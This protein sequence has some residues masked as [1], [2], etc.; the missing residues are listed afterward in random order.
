MNGQLTLNAVDGLRVDSAMHV[1]TGFWSGFASAA[2]VFM[3][4]EVLEGSPSYV[5]P[6]QG[7]MGS[8]LNY[9]V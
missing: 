7:Y 8:V 3:T 6:Y 1:D 9:P 2:G 5:C 4:G